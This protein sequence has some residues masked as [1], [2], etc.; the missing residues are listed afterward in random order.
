[1]AET[2]MELSIIIKR[3][4]NEV[5]DFVSRAE[6]MPKWAEKIVDAAQT[7]EGAIE[8]GT[9]CYVTVRA[10]GH[11]ARQDFVVTE[12]VE[13]TTYAAKSTS[14]PVHM[15][16]RYDLESTQEGTKVH[17]TVVANMGG[18]MAVAGPFL[19]RKMK[20]QFEEDHANLKLLLES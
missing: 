17:A 2:R 8:V 9:T 5:F 16:T 20:K 3:P 4:I 19:A 10:M 6:N 18:L 7:S 14:G 12:C 13:D 11:E 1:M 15:E